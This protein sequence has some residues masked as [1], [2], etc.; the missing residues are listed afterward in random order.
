MTSRDYV[1]TINTKDNG[2]LT[3]D[4]A[5]CVRLSDRLS[6]AIGSGLTYFIFQLERGESGRFHC[7]GYL[8]FRNAVRRRAV[9]RCL[10]EDSA[11]VDKRRGTVD[12]AKS[13]A[14]KEETRCAGPWE[15][16]VC[17]DGQG[18]RTD[19]E[20][21]RQRIADGA[22]DLD[23]ARADFQAWCSNHRAFERYRQLELASRQRDAPPD[24][25]VYV[26]STGV[27]KS[28]AAHEEF[29]DIYSVPVPPKAG[30]AY[31][32]DG[33]QGDEA[34]LIDDYCGVEY[35][36]GFLLK[37]LDRYRLQVPVKGG[38]TWWLP[39]TIILTSNI[40]PEQWHTDASIE[41]RRALLRRITCIHLF[42]APDVR[43]RVIPVDADYVRFYLPA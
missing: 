40:R 43:A 42:E 26:G 28:R 37:L 31:W 24:V 34:V 33:Y 1:F 13:Y 22:S 35:D 18:R 8:R 19:L 7:Q 23:L 10:G 4:E 36:I 16:G 21:V 20:S 6:G 15:G 5:Y 29:P 38:F 9:K 11:Y 14:S 32:F 17:Q 2:S 27:G 30:S 39:K 3:V 25:R 12:E 41:H